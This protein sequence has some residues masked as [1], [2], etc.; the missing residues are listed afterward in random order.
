MASAVNMQF[1]F[2]ERP[3]QRNY[4]Q[5]SP[6]L[7]TTQQARQQMQREKISLQELISDYFSLLLEEFERSVDNS[8]QRVHK[9]TRLLDTCQ[10]Q[11]DHQTLPE[12]S[13]E[14]ELDF[15]CRFNTTIEQYCALQQRLLSYPTSI[16]TWQLSNSH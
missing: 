2:E 11:H 9:L 7:L 8:K 16:Q 10:Q 6:Q 12:F 13:S 1:Y 5:T 3:Y 4:E 15:W 14:S